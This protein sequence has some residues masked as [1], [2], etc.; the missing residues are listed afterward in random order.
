ASNLG[1]MLAL[2]AYPVVVEHFMRLGLITQS[3]YWTVGYGLFCVLMV[4]CAAAVWKAPEPTEQ[5]KKKQR[6]MVSTTAGLASTPPTPLRILWW[7]GLAFVPSSLMLGCTTY[8]STDLSPGPMIWVLPL[9]LYL[10]SFILVF[11][12]LPSFVHT[13]MI[14]SLPVLI[15]L[16]A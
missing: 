9:G 3:M 12:R 15:L 10:L 2:L 13:L 14:L 8:L 1:S 5:Q 16:Q 4:G 7:V 11:S 6:S